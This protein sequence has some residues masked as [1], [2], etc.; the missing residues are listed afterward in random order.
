MSRAFGS[1]IAVMRGGWWLIATPFHRPSGTLKFH[2]H[3]TLGA[4]PAKVLRIA[5]N[6]RQSRRRAGG[7]PRMQS[8]SSGATAAAF[9]LA[10]WVERAVMSAPGPW[11]RQG[12]AAMPPNVA[13]NSVSRPVRMGPPVCCQPHVSQSRMDSSKRGEAYQRI[14]AATTTPVAAARPKVPRRVRRRPWLAQ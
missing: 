9:P 1:S 7:V 14:T 3:S 10:S 6:S 4:A 11:P 2:V 13:R 12:A 5:S 8:M